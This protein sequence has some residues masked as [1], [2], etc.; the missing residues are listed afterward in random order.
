MGVDQT[1]TAYAKSVPE[2]VPN[3]SYEDDEGNEVIRKWSEWKDDTHE[4]VVIGTKNYVP[5]NAFGEDLKGSELAV[6]HA[7]TGV[8]VLT[9]AQYVTKLPKVDEE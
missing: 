2:G 9:A 1:N 4:H 5:A 6:I 7:L 3:R 8:N